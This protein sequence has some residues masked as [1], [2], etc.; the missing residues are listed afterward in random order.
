MDHGG[1]YLFDTGNDYEY[2]YQADEPEDADPVALVRHGEQILVSDFSRDRLDAYSLDGTYTGE[3]LPGWLQTEVAKVR[4]QRA[5]YQQIT[6]ILTW[7]FILSLA[8]GFAYALFRQFRP[9]TGRQ[10]YETAVVSTI[11]INDPAIRWIKPDKKTRRTLYLLPLL[12]MSLLI[13]II[14]LRAVLDNVQTG[15][16]LASLVAMAVFALL[17]FAGIYNSLGKQIGVLGDSLIIKDRKGNYSIGTGS[18]IQYSDAAIL[19]GNRFVVLGAQPKIFPTDQMVR[20]V[21]PVL[22][23]AE[24]VSQSR[25]QRLLLRNSKVFLLV[26]ILLFSALIG[27]LIYFLR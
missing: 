26:M 24:F 12:I 21:Y 10:N 8:G 22:Q 15:L 6:D 19:I 17:L 18:Q 4:E 1:I 27:V 7:L 20:Y 16:D 9:E 11:N 3:F 23:G 13:G 5:F 2:S 25:M 14:L